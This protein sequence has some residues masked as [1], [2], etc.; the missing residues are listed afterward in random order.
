M[1]IELKGLSWLRG[2]WIGWGIWN[3][4]GLHDQVVIETLSIRDDGGPYLIAT[5]TQYLADGGEIRGDA[6]AVSG[7]RGLVRGQVWAHETL[8]IRVDPTQ[9]GQDRERY[10]VEVMLANPAG[11]VGCARAVASGGEHGGQLHVRFDHLTRAAGAAQVETVE[12]DYVLRNDELYV[13]AMMS[14]FGQH[15][16]PYLQLRLGKEENDAQ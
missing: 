10:D 5:S 1:S 7:A 2:N 3:G 13:R 9:A 15:D 6:P 11:Y 12:R 14:A 8:Y 16:V 4:F